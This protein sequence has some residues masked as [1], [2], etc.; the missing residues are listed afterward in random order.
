MGYSAGSAVAGLLQ[1]KD[2]L[3]PDDV[4][5]IILHDHG[6]RYVGKIYNDDWMRE[7][8]F[9]EKELTVR[10]IIKAHAQQ[11][12]ITIGAEDKVR[13]ALDLMKQYDIS[14]LPVMKENEIVG[15]LSENSLLSFILDNPLNHAEKPV[16]EIMDAPFPMVEEDLPLSK[17]TQYINKKVPAV[18]ARDKAGN[19]FILSQYDILQ[20]M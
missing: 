2:R 19:L 16:S 1:L 11:K 9:L 12:L 6:S 3:K 4:V 13:H 20:M 10:D 7:R 18:M 15:S 17:L 5:V 14:Q 8:G